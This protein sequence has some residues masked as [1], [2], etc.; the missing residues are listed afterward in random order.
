MAEAVQIITYTCEKDEQPNSVR[1]RGSFDEWTEE[2][3]M[4][5]V[6]LEPYRIYAFALPATKQ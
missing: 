5:Q 3:K 1:V 2:H 4:D 6:A